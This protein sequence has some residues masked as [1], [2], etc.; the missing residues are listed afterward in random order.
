MCPK[1][2]NLETPHWV[3]F[4][5][6]CKCERVIWSRLIS[7][8]TKV[9]HVHIWLYYDENRDV[10]IGYH[11]ITHDEQGNTKYSIVYF[12]G[13]NNLL[14]VDEGVLPGMP[15]MCGAVICLCI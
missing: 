2:K 13:L 4:M 12:P 15:R 11:G 9:Q 8:P 3:Q 7:I 6:D 10:L 14:Q 1:K 5:M